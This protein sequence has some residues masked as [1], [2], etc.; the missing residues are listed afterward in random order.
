[1]TDGAHPLTV[2]PHGSGVM[3]HFVGMFPLAWL[4]GWFVGLI[5]TVWKLL[6]GGAPP[7]SPRRALRIFRARG[8]RPQIGQSQ[9]TSM[10]A[11]Q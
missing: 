5:A 1:M 11:M 9:G 7:R 2:V 8:P 6:S 3:R 4:G 10:M